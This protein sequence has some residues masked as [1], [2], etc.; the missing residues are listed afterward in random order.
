MTDI[1]EDIAAAKSNGSGNTTTNVI[2]RSTAKAPRSKKISS[3]GGGSSR[4]RY[5]RRKKL[6]QKPKRQRTPIS[7]DTAILFKQISSGAG[8]CSSRRRHSRRKKQKRELS[9]ELNS[10]GLSIF[11][12]WVLRKDRHSGSP[13]CGARDLCRHG[14][15]SCSIRHRWDK[16]GIVGRC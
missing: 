15:A 9:S 1:L 16:E 8:G 12:K 10:N 2:I 11:W 14:S 4:R 6:L 7:K 13:S 5:S 3:G